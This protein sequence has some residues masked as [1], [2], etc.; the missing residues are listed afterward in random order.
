MTK[1]ELAH[2]IAQELGEDYGLTMRIVQRTF[3]GIIE[4]LEQEGRLELRN[5]GVFQVK[6]RKAR[7]AR[8]PRTGE[9][10]A[11]PS[12]ATVSFKPGQ[13]MLERVNQNMTPESSP[14][15]PKEA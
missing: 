7:M 15:A 14:A 5:F 12:R 13:E 10:V 2:K 4:T 11:V 1:K 6:K 8:N 9:K 3:D